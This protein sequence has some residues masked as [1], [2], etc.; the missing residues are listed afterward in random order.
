MEQS[1][2]TGLAL[3]LGLILA[4]G[5][6][7]AFVLAHS[8]RR[9][10]HVMIAFTCFACD[11]LLISAGVFGLA[12]LIASS[13]WLVQLTRWGGAGFLFVYGA[14]ALRRALYPQVLAAEST[15]APSRKRILLTTLAITF[16]NPHVY[17]DTVVLL[18]SLGAQQSSRG[19]FALG[20]ATGSFLWFFGLALGAAYFARWL[21]RP[22]TWRVIDLTVAVMMFW[23]G[24]GLTTTSP[25]VA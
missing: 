24:W 25:V 14:L 18:G 8:L 15:T 19:A 7:N 2:F 17:L 10:H 12:S 3:G 20:A 21:A 6:Q 23:I 22:L 11:A 13:E 1:Y 16:L 4:I 9:Q 5:A